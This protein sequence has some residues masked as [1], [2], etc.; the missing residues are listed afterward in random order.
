M[1]EY[2]YLFGSYAKG[3]QTEKNDVDLLVSMQVDGIKTS[4]L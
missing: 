1:L 3:N 4:N 2:C